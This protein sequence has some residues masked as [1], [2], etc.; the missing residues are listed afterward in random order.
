[1]PAFHPVLLD[2]VVDVSTLSTDG[3]ADILLPFIAFVLT[4]SIEWPVFA[5]ITGQGFKKTFVFMLLM[6][7]V[8]WP[9]AMILFGYLSVHIVWVELFV[10]AAETLI[11][12][13]HWR[14]PWWKAL[15][16]ATIINA[17]SFFIGSPLAQFIM[18]QISGK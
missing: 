11:L 17:A 14:F 7:L 16:F 9:I 2:E 13:Y 8:S 4:F 1:M 12:F 6:N 10:L 3:G 18:N 5:L 15:L